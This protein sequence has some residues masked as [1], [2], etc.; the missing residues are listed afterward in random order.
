MLGKKPTLLCLHC[1][2]KQKAARIRCR[3]CDRAVLRG[4][5]DRFGL[6]DTLAVS[7]DIVTYK[8]WDNADC[9]PVVIRL[10]RKDA[11]AIAKQQFNTEARLLAEMGAG[12]PFP[13]FLKG[14]VHHLTGLAF[15][16][17][18]FLEGSPFAEAARKL[19]EKRRTDLVIQLGQIVELL[20]EKGIVHGSLCPAHI[21]VGKEGQVMLL[22]FRSARQAGSP[23]HGL[24]A[25]GYKAPEQYTGMAPVSPAT[26]VFALG[27]IGYELLT[28]S[29]PYGKHGRDLLFETGYVPPSPSSLNAYVLP[30]LDEVVLQAIRRKPEERYPD[31][32]QFGAALWRV[33]GRIT[34]VDM[35]PVPRV[36][37]WHV[38]FAALWRPRLAATTLAIA[39]SVWGSYWLTTNW[40]QPVCA[41]QFLS[42]P[43]SQVYVDGVHLGEAPSPVK[44]SFPAGTHHVEMRA[45]N[46]TPYGFDVEFPNENSLIVKV[47]IERA[48]VELDAG[49]P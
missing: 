19:P 29:L 6:H 41:V 46:A 30:E 2:R 9:R 33:M 23:S 49:A 12:A 4:I 17:Y 27:T 47:D 32:A 48:S 20:H 38:W 28:G 18:E 35:A 22:N 24:G 14:G 16:V 39:G 44:H 45:R 37:R 25:P 26:D 3:R 36:P 8:A 43:P 15:A 10:L 13:A 31:A 40:P 5:G 42:W 7:P 1:G 21:V 11:A 34:D